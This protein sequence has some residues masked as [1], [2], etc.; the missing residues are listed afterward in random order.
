MNQIRGSGA[1]QKAYR[2]KV[3]LI[4]IHSCQGRFHREH[5]DLSLSKHSLQRISFHPRLTARIQ[6]N[7]VSPEEPHAQ[8]KQARYS[9]VS[10]SFP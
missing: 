8:S 6:Y 5:S 7:S 3:Q 4:Q 10:R 2:V 9:P 1:V